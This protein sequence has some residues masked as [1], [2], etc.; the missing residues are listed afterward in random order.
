MTARERE[1]VDRWNACAYYRLI[2]M[3]AVSASEGTAV[4]ELRVGEEHHQAYGS[5]H[6]GVLAGLIDA[7]M[8]LAILG[9]APDGEGCATIEMK[10][11]Y[12]APAVRGTLTAT[13][14][15]LHEGRRMVVASAEARDDAGVL[16]SA[17]QGTFQRFRPGAG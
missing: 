14:R 11:N 16:V 7:A 12:T 3:R 10:L 9:A 4:L 6:G 2:G 15:I 5:A 17:G 1:I 13:G 8:G